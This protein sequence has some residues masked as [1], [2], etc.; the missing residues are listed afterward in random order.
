MMNDSD[1]ENNEQK[2]SSRWPAISPAVPSDSIFFSLSSTLDS[3]SV[4]Y[5]FVRTRGSHGLGD[6]VT[7]NTKNTRPRQRRRSTRRT[8]LHLRF[9]FDC[10][11][12]RWSSLCS[13]LVCQQVSPATSPSGV[14]AVRAC[15][16][17]PS[18]DVDR[19]VSI[20]YR[21][22]SLFIDFQRP[23]IAKRSA[24]FF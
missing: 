18:H 6:E 16:R 20:I 17:H 22:Q 21:S 14:G 1:D 5:S 8:R 13:R 24:V 12:L 11:P 9:A 7:P 19:N 3:L 15:A 2:V 4:Y 23:F 10:W